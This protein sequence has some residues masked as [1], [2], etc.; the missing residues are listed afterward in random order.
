MPTK[1]MS[2]ELRISVAD[3]GSGFDQFAGSGSNMF[4]RIRIPD[5][6]CWMVGLTL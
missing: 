6:C 3:P 1:Q 4:S 2:T 5:P